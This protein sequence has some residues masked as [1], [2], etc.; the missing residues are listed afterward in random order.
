MHGFV[1]VETYL[2]LECKGGIWVLEDVLPVGGSLNIY[3]D[4]KAGKS[5]LAAQIASGVATPSVHEVVGIP[6]LQHGP[7]VYFQMDT[8]RAIWQA[9]FL[10][11]KHKGYPF[12]HVYMGDRQM[13]PYPFDVQ[14]EGGA[15]LGAQFKELPVYPV[16]VIIDTTREVHN[17]NENSSD[18][19]KHVVDQIEHAAKPAAVIY[20]S[21]ARKKHGDE[22]SN[23][24]GDARGS[25]YIP[26][27][28]DANMKM[29]L[30]GAPGP[31]IIFSSRTASEAR[32][33]L[34]KDPVD[35]ELHLA[36]KIAAAARGLVQ[37][38]PDGDLTAMSQQLDTQFHGSCSF[39]MLRGTLSRM[40]TIET[41]LKR[42]RP[43]PPTVADLPPVVVT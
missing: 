17:G 15:W 11:L 31:S 16:L 18:V 19:M 40:R 9:R 32:Y 30:Q 2:T 3:G 29:D 36:D 23:L 6:I 8:P 33:Q 4:P 27:R 38:D 12:Q 21:H 20:I 37:A 5:M 26:G 39:D 42:G 7:V 13:T 43:Y 1:T 34:G 14:L 10:N 25:S 35:G 28:M 24:I 41:Y 22:P